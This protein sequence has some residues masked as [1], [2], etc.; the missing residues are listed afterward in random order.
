MSRVE[1]HRGR[2]GEVREQGLEERDGGSSAAGTGFASF[3]VAV[4][5]LDAAEKLLSE[6]YP[7]G[8]M[9]PPRTEEQ[10]IMA[11]TYFGG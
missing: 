6:G 4:V 5:L 1:G 11:E 2:D 7:S 3:G 8:V 9:L 10:D